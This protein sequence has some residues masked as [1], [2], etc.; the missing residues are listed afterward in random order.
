MEKEKKEGFV[1]YCKNYI[2][3]HIDDYEGQDHYACDF[4]M[5]LTEGPN[6]DGS[7]TYSSYEAKQYLKEW[8]D[9][10]GEYWDYEKDNFGEHTHNPFDNPEAYMVCMVIEGVA[11]ILSNCPEIEDN[12]NEKI[13]LT[14]E[15]IQNIKDYVEVFNNDSLF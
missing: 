9:E 1:E 13:E 15:V 6:I 2:L 5:T 12:W 3:E 14:A 7:L 11:S 10:C 4:A 8:W